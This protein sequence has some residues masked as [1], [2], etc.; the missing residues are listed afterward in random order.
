MAVGTINIKFLQ[1][2]LN[3][4]SISYSLN[5]NGVPYSVINK[6]FKTPT[7][8]SSSRIVRT[9]KADLTIDTSFNVGSGF[10]NPSLNQMRCAM[11][12]DGKLIVVGYFT[13]YNGST[14]NGIVRLNVDGSVDTSFVTG[15]GFN[16]GVEDVKIQSNGDVICVG[17]FTSYKGTT[18]NRIIRLKPDGSIDSTFTIGSGFNFQADRIA[19]QSDG[20]IIVGGQF[21]TYNGSNARGLCRLNSNGTLDATFNAGTGLLNTTSSYGVYG[22]EILSSGKILIS[23]LFPSYNGNTCNSIA[24]INSDGS[25]DSTFNSGGAGIA[26]SNKLV[27]SLFVQADGKILITGKFLT[28]NTNTVNGVA[29]LNSDGSFDSTFNT[30]GSGLNNNMGTFITQQSDNTILLMGEFSTFNGNNFQNL[31]K[32]DVDGSIINDNQLSFNNTVVY[33]LSTTDKVYFLGVFTTSTSLY[34]STNDFIPIGSVVSNTQQYSRDNLSTFNSD[35]D[36]DYT[37]DGDTV[38]VSITYDELNDVLTLSNVIDVPFFVVITFN[39]GLLEPVGDLVFTDDTITQIINP[40]YNNTII[41]YSTTINDVT[42]SEIDVNGTIYRIDPFLNSFTFNF[43]EIAKNLINPNYFKDEVVP[44]ILS[45]A[46]VDDSTLSL[47]LNAE[48][49]VFDI[50]NEFLT[51]NKTIKFLKNVEQLPNYIDRL[52]A[53]QPVRILLPTSNY[54]E[55]YLP[56]FEGYPTD[57]SIF[58]LQTNDEFF[59]KNTSNYFT[60]ETFTATTSEVKRFFISDGQNESSFIGDLNLASTHN[61]VELW[62]NNSFVSNVMINKKESNCG[63][64]LKWFNNSGSYSYWLFEEPYTTT[65]T[66]KSMDDITGVYD[67]LQNVTST[68]NIIGKRGERKIKLKT[69]YTNQEKQ[70]IQSILSSPKVEMYAYNQPFIATNTNAFFGITVNDGSFTDSSKN[71]NNTLEI[72]ITLPDLFTQTL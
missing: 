36:I 46:I 70:Y 51:A 20:K 64:Y 33:A 28:Y 43:K 29:R 24:R 22:L 21:T 62:V 59:L 63:V 56:Y 57:F 49:K 45:N 38:Q 5:K 27:R 68:S 37:I 60:T 19:I 11:Q 39:D 16:G 65:N 34:Q 67:N 55:Y 15:I 32:L 7:V 66:F 4:Q 13:Q 54:T 31:V 72:T 69:K 2:P 40:A 30:G 17:F 71:S 41:R 18:R 53:A 6:T 42:H 58:G 52:A 8:F 26:G 10:N 23:G 3:N 12:S 44:D 35:S 25:F 48:I 9:N 47:T 50:N 14:A 1:N 61:N